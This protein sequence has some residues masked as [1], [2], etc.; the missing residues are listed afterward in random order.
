M[1]KILNTKFLIFT[2][3]V[4]LTI[5]FA[6]S[7][8]IYKLY[9]KYNTST[10]ISENIDTNIDVYID[11]PENVTRIGILNNRSTL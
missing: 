5:C 8:S 7:F 6:L 10:E 1:K 4:L 2:N 9:S 11:R 3:L